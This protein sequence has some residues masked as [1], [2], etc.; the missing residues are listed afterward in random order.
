[1]NLPDKTDESE[2]ILVIKL[3]AL[4]DFIQALGPMA[5]IRKHHH[6]AEITILTTKP[7]EKFAERCGYF[8]RIWI[9]DKPGWLSLK[10]W[11]NF[12]KRLN[13][14][15]YIRVYDLQN[16]DRSC[17]YFRLLK[18]PRPEWVG[19]A[20]GASHRNT[21]PDRTNGHAFDGH[22]QTLA[23]AGIENVEIDTLSW[24][25]E[26]ISSFPVNKPYILLVPG[27]APE[28]EYKR[29]PAKHYGNLA[30]VISKWGYQPVI[31]GNKAE[32]NLTKDILK[33]TPEI[34]NLCSQ[35]SLGQIS[36]LARG[37]TGAIGNDTGPMHLIAATSCPCLSLFSGKSN[38]VRH[39]PKGAD[40]Q[41]IQESNLENL[42]VDRVLKN[43][44]PREEPAKASS[45]RRY[46]QDGIK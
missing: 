21:H 26:D 46:S 16:N 37:A 34:L 35:T 7:Y 20:S 2:R 29:W 15:K 19:T 22:A 11:A 24:L 13:R 33:I 18:N 1:M 12:K 40:V 30:K 39:V 6:N 36:A 4:G 14:G 38:T 3:G 9:D 23:L 5:S 42:D 43:F 10:I 17:F 31:I 8:D 25:D 27:S 28:H 41:L 45:T 44:R 32:E